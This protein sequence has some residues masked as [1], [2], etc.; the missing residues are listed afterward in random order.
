MT[1]QAI[2]LHAGD[3]HRLGAYE[4]RPERAPR[5]GLV[6]LQEIFGVTAHIRRVC[7][8]FAAHG[9]HVVAPA[10]FDR[11]GAGIALG[12]SKE[13]AA[14]GRDLRGRIA[15]DEV[16][17]D[18]LAAKDRLRGSGKVATLGYCWGGTISWRCATQVE[19]VA[20]SI[21]YYPTQIGPHTDERPRCPVLMHFG[22]QDPIATL[23]NAGA[24]RA[25]HNSQV[26]GSLVEIQVY[27]ASHGF[28]CGD[29]PS[30][31]PPSADLALRRSLDFLATH[32]G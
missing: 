1:G 12:Y 14:R 18:V 11:M 27:P 8:D 23:A 2:A 17:S 19:D 3:G 29:I 26:D 6:L 16:F 5:G 24:L 21:C 15:W 32:L 4:A 7:D 13:E 20:G 28:N 30:F 22:E 25:A 9:Y 10:L 31:H